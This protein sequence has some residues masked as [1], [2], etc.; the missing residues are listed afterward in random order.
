MGLGF[1]MYRRIF[2]NED[3]HQYTIKQ[4]C[5]TGNESRKAFTV[6]HLRHDDDGEKKNANN[7]NK[8]HE[9]DTSSCNKQQ[10][11]RTAKQCMNL[12]TLLAMGRRLR[13]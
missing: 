10:R 2:R 6:S 12:I 11:Y 1:T 9:D 5:S 13:V 4:G 7:D 8:G 3:S